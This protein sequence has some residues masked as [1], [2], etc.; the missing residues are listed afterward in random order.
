ME[1]G[2][3]CAQLMGGIRYKLTQLTDG[4]INALQELIESIRQAA[5]FIMSECTGEASRILPGW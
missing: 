4:G 3:W 2:E 1:N 5:Q